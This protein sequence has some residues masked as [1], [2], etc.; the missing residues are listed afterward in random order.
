MPD[1]MKNWRPTDHW[2]SIQWV[3]N[4]NSSDESKEYSSNDKNTDDSDLQDNDQGSVTK[5]WGSSTGE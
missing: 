2:P 3:E 5:T 1:T 4:N